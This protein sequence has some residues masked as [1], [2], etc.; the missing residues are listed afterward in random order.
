MK[1]R[2]NYLILC[3]TY[4]FIYFSNA[5]FL[6][7]FQIF[8]DGKG[9]SESKIGIISSITPLLCIVANPIY[10]L[11]GKNNK[12]IYYLLLFLC[13]MEAIVIL[14]VYKINSFSILIAV[15]CL[16]AM[17]DPPLFI[18]LD[19]YA[20]SY[21]KENNANYS[22]IRMVGTLSYAI[23]TFI[24]GLLIEYSGYSL[25]FYSASLLM[26]LS[27]ILVVFLKTNN[28]SF[29]REKGDIKS[30]LSNKYFIIF[31]IYFIFILAFQ[32]LGDTYI[33]IYLTNEKDINK[34]TFGIISS[35]WVIIELLTIIILN[36]FKI[37]NEQ[38][39]L[40][41][42]GSCYALRMIFIGINAH[43]F[44]VIFGAL[45]RGIGMAIYIYL[46][47]PILNKLI[48]ASNVSLALLI[49]GMF[50]SLLSTLMI[51][52]T[53]FIIEK[54]G[55]NLIF[56]IWAIFIILSIF[57]YYFFSKKVLKNDNQLV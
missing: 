21:V 28:K 10:S 11:F 56:S 4:F 34:S 22:Y 53:G 37:K 40:I 35:L 25:V 38:L 52:L 1:M 50:K 27:F 17:I 31:S 36:N 3:L 30:L 44:F 41:F 29:D 45:L 43:V 8:L 54:N 57:L 47:I 49:I 2:K 24:A 7:F 13:L 33:S 51:S 6:A 39:L 19:S 46:Y 32:S 15:M 9:F 12:R 23:G 16:V 14:L 48:K 18:I 42:M 55:Y 5:L 26:I 20:S